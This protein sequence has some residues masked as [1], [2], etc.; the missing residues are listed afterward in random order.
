MFPSVAWVNQANGSVS[1]ALKGMH[2]V[3]S[4]GLLMQMVAK[5]DSLSR[6]FGGTGGCGDF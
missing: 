2:A 1:T 4:T 3:A 5:F 6:D